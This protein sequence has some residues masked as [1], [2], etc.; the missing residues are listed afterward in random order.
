M[1][2]EVHTIG[3]KD[4]PFGCITRDMTRHGQ[5]FLIKK[6]QSCENIQFKETKPIYSP[7]DTQQHLIMY[8]E[9]IFMYS[10]TMLMQIK[11]Q[12]RLWEFQPEEILFHQKCFL[13]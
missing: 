7:K 5:A 10:Q 9:E 12:K 4:K 8:L 13:P 6:M 2:L 11:Q 1:V 3:T